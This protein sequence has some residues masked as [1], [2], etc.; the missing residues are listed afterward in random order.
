MS[1]IFHLFISFHSD[2]SYDSFQFKLVPSFLPC[3]F[4]SNFFQLCLTNCFQLLRITLTPK[5]Q[6]NKIQSQNSHHS[7]SAKTK[8]KSPEKFQIIS[9]WAFY[10]VYTLSFR[11][12]NFQYTRELFF[13]FGVHYWHH[14]TS[15]LTFMNFNFYFSSFRSFFCFSHNKNIY[16]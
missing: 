10:I 15:K 3:Y 16:L 12:I 11:T 1:L 8:I 4:L 5:R 6:K 13:C 9:L 14:H 2:L 7:H